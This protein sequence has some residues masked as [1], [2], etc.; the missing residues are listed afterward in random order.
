MKTYGQHWK[1]LFVFVFPSKFFSFENNGILNQLS[2]SK[3]K[4]RQKKLKLFVNVKGQC[5][6]TG[7]LRD[8]QLGKQNKLKFEE[9]NSTA[10]D[11]K[12]ESRPWKTI[13]FWDRKY[14]WKINKTDIREP[15]RRW[16]GSCEHWQNGTFVRANNLPS[17]RRWWECW[18]Q[19]ETIFAYSQTQEVKELH[20]KRKF[21]IQHSND[22]WQRKPTTFR[23]LSKTHFFSL[24]GQIR[25]GIFVP[26][27]IH[28]YKSAIRTGIYPQTESHLRFFSKDRPNDGTKKNKIKQII[29]SFVF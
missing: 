1:H 16:K 17:K 26:N 12:N 20:Q 13:R 23:F 21:P 8:G 24:F 7:C 6:E 5:Q 28:I 10:K 29:F 14:N 18:R 9:K 15:K 27:E 3:K 4:Y 25:K 2:I 22:N 19:M 11:S